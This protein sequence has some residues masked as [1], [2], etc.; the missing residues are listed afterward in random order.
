MLSDFIPILDKIKPGDWDAAHRLI[1]EHSD[2]L[3]CRI[4][5]YLHRQEVHLGEAAY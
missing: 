3:G 5:A 4:H 1:Q 2:F